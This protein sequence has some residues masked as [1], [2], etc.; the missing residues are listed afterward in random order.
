MPRSKRVYDTLFGKEAHVDVEGR[1]DYRT[2]DAAFVFSTPLDWKDACFA[3]GGTIGFNRGSPEEVD[4]WHQ[5]AID[6]G[7]TSVED[8]P[9][10]R[11]VSV[12]Q[13]VP[14][15]RAQS[16]W[17]QALRALPAGP[18]TLEILSDNKS[19]GGRQLVVKHASAATGTDMTFSIFLPPQA[20]G[21]GS[22]RSSGTSRA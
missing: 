4:A 14:R 19:H 1:H 20:E 6:N 11:E 22:C 13:A 17:Q 3:N 10:I 8:P 18:M 15:L 12:R 9:G 16:G 5:T 2:D 21:A 7:G